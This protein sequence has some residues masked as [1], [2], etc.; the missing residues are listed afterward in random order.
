MSD[1]YSA[2]AISA[3]GMKAQGARTRVISENLA[4]SD[5][6]PLKAGQDPYARK[7]ITFK[8]VLDKELGGDK[9]DVA[10][11]APDRKKPFPLKYMPDHPAAD[12]NGYVKM[13][14]VD[15]LVETMDMREAQ[16]SYEAN[17]G[18]MDQSRSMIS[19]TIDIL[20]H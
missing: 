18:M 19:E 16:R 11:I 20:R 15:P 13:P 14:N 17:L 7:T 10:R 5:T 8:N 3:S 6:T 4:N 12:S 9:V 2:M 1:L